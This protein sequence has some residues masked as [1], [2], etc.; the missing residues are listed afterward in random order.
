MNE[1]DRSLDYY[2]TLGQKE[3]QQGSRSKWAKTRLKVDLGKI[4]PVLTPPLID[5]YSLP[6]GSF[7]IQFKFELLKPYL[8]RDDNQ[9]Y[10]V[11]NPIVRDKVF[12]FPM[13]RPTAWKGALRHALWQLGSQ[14]E[15]E[16][17]KRLFGVANDDEPQ[18]GNSGRLYFYP[19][20][21]TQTSMEVINPH[22]REKRIGKNPILIESVPIG[23]KATFTLL[24]TPLDRIN[25]D[26]AETR[27]QILADLQRVADGLKAMFTM[28]GFGAKTSSGFGLARTTVKDGTLVVK[29]PDIAFPQAEAA[30]V[31]KPDDEYLKYLDE[32]GRIQPAFAGSGG[33]GFMSNS[34]YKKTGKQSGGGSLSEFRKF[35]QWYREHSEQ[36]QASLK[37]A[38]PETTYPTFSFEQFD[39]LKESLRQAGGDV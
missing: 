4:P 10:I 1:E 18:E 31:Q 21:F 7:S 5:L 20:F 29:L 12:R 23:A 11:D 24:Y 38:T 37:A 17:I 8:S 39:Q 34:E 14:E 16:S 2:A 9:F 30:T 36:W 27:R 28:Y 13:V 19:S 22:N 25:K 3:F 33:V 35:R 32:S 26:K 6:F 15:D